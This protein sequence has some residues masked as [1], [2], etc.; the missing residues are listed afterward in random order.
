[1]TYGSVESIPENNII[2]DILET[3]LGIIKIFLHPCHMVKILL[4]VNPS[5]PLVWGLDREICTHSDIGISAGRSNAF[6]KLKWEARDL[7][8]N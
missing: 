4:F 5:C 3:D 8:G 6:Y 7:G 2:F 1:M